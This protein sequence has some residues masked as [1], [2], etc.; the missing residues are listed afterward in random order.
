MLA[1]EA[2]STNTLSDHQPLVRNPILNRFSNLLRG[3]DARLSSDNAPGYV[4]FGSFNEQSDTRTLGTFAGVFSPVTLS[5]FSALIFLRMGIYQI[6]HKCTLIQHSTFRF[7]RGQRRSISHISTIHNCVRNLS[8]YCNVRLC[9]FDEWS[10]RGRR[11]VLYPFQT[12]TIQIPS[13]NHL[14]FVKQL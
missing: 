4:E 14:T 8:F 5:M 1:P 11:S 7:H 13:L 2:P 3:R 12:I 9:D 10:R 6:N